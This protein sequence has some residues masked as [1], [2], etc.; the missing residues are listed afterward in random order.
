MGYRDD[1]K[2]GMCSK[3]TQFVATL[4]EYDNF[5][6]RV[7]GECQ[8]SPNFGAWIRNELEESEE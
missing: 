5:T 6:R 4:I 3:P 2:C 7:C 8:D 1:G